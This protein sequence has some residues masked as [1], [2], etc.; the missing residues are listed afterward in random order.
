MRLFKKVGNTIQILSFP[1]EDAEKGG[2]LIV[3]DIK[4]EKAMIVQVIDIQFANVPGVLEELLRAPTTEDSARGEDVDPLDVMSHILFIQDARLLLC[5]IH[6]TVE[7]GRLSPEN[8]WLPSRTHS[9]IGRLPTEELLELAG[10]TKGLPIDLGKAQESSPIVIDACELDGKLNVITGKKGTGKSHLSK[11]LVLGLIEHGATVVVL[12]L[13]GEYRN[14][15]LTAEGEKNEYYSRVH[16]LSPGKNFKVTLYQTRL[17]VIMRTLTYAL[18]LPS[19]SA[20]EFKH[21]WRFLEERGTLT[22]HELGEAIKRWK[23]NSHVRDAMSSRYNSLVHSGFFTDN[24]AEALDFE[25]LLRKTG[26]NSGGAMIVDLSD[27]SPTDRQM[28]VEYV[29]AKLQELLSHWKIKAVFLFAEEAHL[30]L[31]ETYWDD[32]VTR[33]RHYGFFT[34]FIT[35]QP[36]TIHE[37]IYRQADN[38]FLLNFVN[39][40]DLQIVSR[41]ARVD[42]ET[43]ISIVRDLPPHQCLVLGKVVRDFPIV[44]K[45]RPLNIKTMGQ[46][47]YF[48]KQS[49]SI[50]QRSSTSHARS[51]RS[52]EQQKTVSAR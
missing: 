28:I 25:G 30:Y 35:N 18:K 1:G 51:S 2:Y 27:T 31:R 33:M 46:T 14:L 23:C 19:T 48:W 52:S 10:M 38:V 43:A 29:L 41:A 7:N 15:G 40:H 24:M 11:L 49:E 47:R 21:V 5:K 8:S 12:D 37:N 9:R 20:R 36:N 3:E 45:V 22:L 6:G 39:E 13:N 32:M 4:A 16:V 34:T 42:A 50:S 17:Y 26:S 44:V